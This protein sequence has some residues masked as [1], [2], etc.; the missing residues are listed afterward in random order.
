MVRVRS[1][2]P[3]CY[4]LSLGI[5]LIGLSE[6]GSRYFYIIFPKLLEEVDM[7]LST[8]HSSYCRFPPLLH[9]AILD[10]LAFFPFSSLSCRVSY[11]LFSFVAFLTNTFTTITWTGLEP[12]LAFFP[13]STMYNNVSYSPS[14]QPLKPCLL[15]SSRFSTSSMLCSGFT[16]VL[17]VQDLSRAFA[18]FSSSFLTFHIHVLPTLTLAP[19]H[20]LR[21]G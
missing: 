2:Y 15:F 8:V 5:I 19:S 4:C 16:S 17:Q 3:Y 7:F 9:L 21:E 14:S 12:A 1:L 13:S 20:W 18:P 10:K 6:T 11:F